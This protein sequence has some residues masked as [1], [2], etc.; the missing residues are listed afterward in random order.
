VDGKHLFVEAGRFNK[1]V[2]VDFSWVKQLAD[3]SN[4][5][6]L[7]RQDAERRTKEDR[8]TAAKATCP[9]VEKL[10]LVINGAVDEFNKHCMFPHL[11]ITLSKLYKHSK[12]GEQSTAEP[13]EVAYFTFQR[14]G[15][16]FGIRGENG[17]VEFVQVPIS[18]DS[19]IV[20]LRLN[21][22]ALNARRSMIAELEPESQKVR[23]MLDGQAIDG[24]AIVSCCQ[25][26]FIE[27]IELTNADLK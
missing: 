13:D 26:F 24:P 17:L 11:R 21:E 4:Q 15:Y 19:I 5:Q 9:F 27:L 7:N 18:T 22:M 2:C 1:G 8:R 12:T 6:E 14:M 23:W 3:T 25:K 16:M 20:N 10:H